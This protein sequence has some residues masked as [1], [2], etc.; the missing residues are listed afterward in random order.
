MKRRSVE[1]KWKAIL[2]YEFSGSISYESCDIPT[3]EKIDRLIPKLRKA[4]LATPLAFSDDPP[5][6]AYPKVAL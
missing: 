2:A 4:A 1:S 6:S 3:R 5:L